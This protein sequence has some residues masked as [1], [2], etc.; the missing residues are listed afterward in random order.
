MKIKS[1]VVALSLFS[2]S[3]SLFV[4]MPSY[5]ANSS[6]CSNYSNGKCYYSPSLASYYARIRA[7]NTENPN[8]NIGGTFPYY[9][10]EAANCTNFASQAIL[11]GLM[12]SVNKAT[13][14]SNRKEFNTDEDGGT[15]DQKWYF[16]SDSDRGPAFTGANKMY[17]YAVNNKNSW[18]GMH[19]DYVSDDETGVID[20]M[21]VKVGDIIFN[22]WQ[23]DGVI[24]H[25]MVVTI[26][27]TS[28][29]SNYGRIKVTYQSVERRDRKLSDVYSQKN[30]EGFHYT[31][32]YVYRP[33]FYSDIGL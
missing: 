30:E 19:F 16:N 26:I 33:T 32:S 8:D 12:G 25:V 15:Y 7:Y 29:T 23:R 24:D 18:K 28:N 3:T 4:S 10:G 27:D 9:T 22:D 11:A 1:I 2:L 31:T 13:I 21:K 17:E 5:S 20:F 14:W 6:S